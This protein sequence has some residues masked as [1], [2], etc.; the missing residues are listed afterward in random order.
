MNYKNG[1]PV[2]EIEILFFGTMVK[3]KNDILG[4]RPCASNSLHNMSPV[5][6]SKRSM[7]TL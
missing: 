4:I 1:L 7:L 5:I 2:K 3:V 6:H